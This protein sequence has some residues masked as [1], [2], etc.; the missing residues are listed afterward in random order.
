MSIPDS[1]R[2]QWLLGK[3]IL[4]GLS[5]TE[6]FELR[7]Y[8]ARE[9]PLVMDLSS[10]DLVDFGLVLIGAELLAYRLRTE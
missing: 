6:L 10:A 4:E 1:E 7:E 3:S 8:I 9:Y 2:M 5:D